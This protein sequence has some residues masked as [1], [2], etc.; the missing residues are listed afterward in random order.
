VNSDVDSFIEM[1]VSVNHKYLALFSSN[2]V[3]WIGSTDLQVRFFCYTSLR[4]LHG[5]Q[6]KEF[7]FLFDGI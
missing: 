3:L 1:T 2:G 7:S 5:K 4:F 6:V